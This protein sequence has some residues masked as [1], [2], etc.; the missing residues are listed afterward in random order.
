M[1]QS[2]GGLKLS[3]P[4]SVKNAYTQAAGTTLTVTASE[5]TAPLNG[6]N[7]ATLSASGTLYLEGI[8]AL[9]DGAVRTFKVAEKFKTMTPWTN[10]TLTGDATG[11][12]VS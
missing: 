6:D 8:G 1:T 10:S 7:T 5:T 11:L 4:L 12:R 9:A 3:G 2:G